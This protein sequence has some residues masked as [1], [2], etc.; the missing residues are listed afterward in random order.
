MSVDF[1]IK[2][3]RKKRN[4]NNDLAIWPYHNRTGE[5]LFISG[6]APA[7]PSSP[8]TS[9]LTTKWKQSMIYLFYPVRTLSCSTK[10]RNTMRFLRNGKLCSQLVKRKA[11]YSWTLRMKMNELS[12]LPM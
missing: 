10:K 7:K 5:A 12:N 6:T 4:I 2:W 11:N 9:S 3:N 1:L 8:D